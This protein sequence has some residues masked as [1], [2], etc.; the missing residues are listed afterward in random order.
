MVRG[1]EPRHARQREFNARH[2]HERFAPVAGP[3]VRRAAGDASLSAPLEVVLSCRDLLCGAE[4]RAELI[5]PIGCP[6]RAL[7]LY[8]VYQSAGEKSPSDPGR[9]RPYADSI[10]K[11]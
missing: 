1:V 9:R 10:T 4:E 6:V 7:R 8:K 3:Y 11:E 5:G 2:P